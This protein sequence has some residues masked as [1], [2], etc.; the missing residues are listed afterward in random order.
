MRCGNN[1]T[2]KLYKNLVMHKRNKYIDVR[3]HFLRNLTKED[4][5]ALVHCR[6]QDQVVDLMTKPLKLDVFLKLRKLLGVQEIS[7]VN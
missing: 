2:I 7:N 1:S 5:V 4:T 6:S 3:Y